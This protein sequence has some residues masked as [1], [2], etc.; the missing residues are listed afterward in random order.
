MRSEKK[1]NGYVGVGELDRF[2]QF[3]LF[4]ELFRRN[5]PSLIDFFS[6]DF[7]GNHHT[8]SFCSAIAKDEFKC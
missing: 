2:G 1:V 5:L 8:R 7:R 3:I 4:A 6:F